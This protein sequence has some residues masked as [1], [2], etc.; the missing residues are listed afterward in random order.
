MSAGTQQLQSSYNNISQGSVVPANSSSY[1]NGSQGSV[2]PSNSS[3]SNVSQGSENLSGSSV[4]DNLY[5]ATP[6][7]SPEVLKSSSNAVKEGGMSFDCV[8]KYAW[9]NDRIF[10]S[11]VILVAIVVI[12]G[13]I[14]GIGDLDESWYQNMSKAAYTPPSYVTFSVWVVFSFITAYLG[15]AGYRGARSHQERN[16]LTMLFM[17]QLGLSLAWIILLFGQEN[18]AVSFWISIILF[19]VVL[20]WMIML[21]RV[22]KVLGIIALVFLAWIGFT[23]AFNWEM[24]TLNKV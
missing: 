2:V 13:W 3:Y 17:V 11:F 21:A 10:W 5:R 7:D 19:I 20:L 12:I 18:P 24:V 15:Y 9:L 22:N 8:N 6:D 4:L 23:V 1:G 14:A 16:I